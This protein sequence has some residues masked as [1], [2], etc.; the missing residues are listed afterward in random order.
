MSSF[1]REKFEAFLQCAMDFASVKGAFS[2]LTALP[3]QEHGFSLH[4]SVGP[5]FLMLLP[6]AMYGH[7][8]GHLHFM[9]ADPLFQ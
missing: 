4:T 8:L 1:L 5:L 6:Y 9:L 7:L 3:L 2:W